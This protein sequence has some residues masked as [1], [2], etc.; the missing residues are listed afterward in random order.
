MIRAEKLSRPGTLCFAGVTPGRGTRFTLQEAT[1]GWG[2]RQAAVTE[3]HPNIVGHR[4][5]QPLSSGGRRASSQGA[6]NLTL[7]SSKQG[8]HSGP[9]PSPA[10][11][12][13]ER[14]LSFP[15]LYFAFQFFDQGEIST[16]RGCPQEAGE[17]GPWPP[18]PHGRASTPPLNGCRLN[19]RHR[20]KT[21]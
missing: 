14:F 13:H 16:G 6:S 8:C 5:G 20:P 18:V 21:C 11:D 4:E 2:E 17:P 9:P 10:P 1:S 19:G 3:G 7:P 15:D 12:K